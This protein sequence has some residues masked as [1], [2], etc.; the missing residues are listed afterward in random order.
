VRTAMRPR[1]NSDVA[2]DAALVLVVGAWTFLWAWWQWSP[3]A[4]SWHF[5]SDG[6]H[7]LLHTSRL[8]LYA[9][10]PSLQIGPL[11]FAVTA[12]VTWLPPHTARV[13]AQV[14]LT[15]AG[16]LMV[17]WL[18]PLVPA[19]RRR[20][21]VLVAA[22]VVVPA[23]TVLSVR[24]AHADDALAMVFTV[25]AIRAVV[26]GR[27]AWAGL[28]LA[29]AV[30][31]KPWAVGFLPLLLVL[32]RRRVLAFATAGAG[33]LG[34]WAPFLI[35][36]GQT[37]QAFHPA[38]PVS[39]DSGLYTLRF[40]GRLVPAWGRTAQLLAAPCV[41]LIAVLRG[42]WPGLFIAAVA[43]RLALDPQDLPYYVGAAAVAAVIFDLLSTR[44]TIPWVTLVTVL[45]LWQ[46][47]VP[48]FATALT[49][50]HGW[51]LW[52]Y[53]HQTTVGVIHVVWAAATIGFVGFAPRRWLDPDAD[54]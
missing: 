54:A 24:W 17:L 39:S 4:I 41:A 19:D 21:R 25:A 48:D 11:T 44:W 45:V 8:H 49:T 10:D 37:M 29:A 28:A 31:C 18:A 52:W 22:V 43:A 12:L 16:P 9:R 15:A 53:S 50:T 51:S 33:I 34:A 38:V 13:V 27:A 30:A 32:D 5:F 6:A 47:F 3:S 14:L 20:A 40:R 35:A 36:D 2:R 1:S 7:A 23:W 42:R 46:P 26:A